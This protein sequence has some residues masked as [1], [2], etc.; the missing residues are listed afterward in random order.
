MQI[1][2]FMIYQRLLLQ[3]K[4]NSERSGLVYSNA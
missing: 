3:I 2:H 4:K 1:L